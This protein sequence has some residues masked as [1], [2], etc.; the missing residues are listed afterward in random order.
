M[1]YCFWFLCLPFM[2]ISCNG[3]NSNLSSQEKEKIKKAKLDSIV[4]VKLNEINKDEVDTFPIFRGLCSDSLPKEEQK[5]CFED[6]FV[7]LLTEKLQKEKLEALEA[8]N[9]KILVNIKVDNSGSIVLVG[10]EASDKVSKT[11]ATAEQSFEEILAM[12]LNNISKENPVI[13]ATKQGLEV[14]SQFTIPI[15]INVK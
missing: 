8:I 12:H 1:K 4:E 11:L 10:L 3:N 13:P 5:K 14:S 2:F 7:K 9:E 6:S 15:A